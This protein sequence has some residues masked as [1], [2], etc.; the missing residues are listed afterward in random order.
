MLR[1]MKS[2]DFTPN[3]NTSDPDRNRTLPHLFKSTCH[4]QS[5]PSIYT[6][7]DQPKQNAAVNENPPASHLP[8]NHNLVADL[9]CLSPA[10]TRST[11]STGGIYHQTTHDWGRRSA[12]DI[13]PPTCP[14]SHRRS[15]RRGARL[16]PYGLLRRP[17]LSV[18]T[19]GYLPLNTSPYACLDF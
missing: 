16:Q 5:N 2:T 18:R 11:S 1:E 3:S 17:R 12:N 8:P 7:R 14:C 19:V 9:A 6:D 10:H 13:S 4:H 15:E